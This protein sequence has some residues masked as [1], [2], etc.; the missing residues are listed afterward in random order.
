MT[1]LNSFLLSETFLDNKQLNIVEGKM[2]SVGL[3]GLS[4]SGNLRRKTM[5]KAMRLGKV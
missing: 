4:M 5:L 3:N 2:L 1:T